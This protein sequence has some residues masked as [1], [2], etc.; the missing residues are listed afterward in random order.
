MEKV[1]FYGKVRTRDSVMKRPY[2]VIKYKYPEDGEK[3]PYREKWIAGN[4]SREFL[5]EGFLALFFALKN[6]ERMYENAEALE[7]KFKVTVDNKAVVE[8]VKTVRIATEWPYSMTDRDFYDTKSYAKCAYLDHSDVLS[9]NVYPSPE[10]TIGSNPRPLE[11]SIYSELFTNRIWTDSIA[12][13][14]YRRVLGDLMEKVGNKP[15][16]SIRATIEGYTPSEIPDRLFEKLEAYYTQV[17]KNTDRYTKGEVVLK[18]LGMKTDEAIRLI[19]EQEFTEDTF[20]DG[21]LALL[22][23]SLKRITDYTISHYDDLCSQDEENV[24]KLKSIREDIIAKSPLDDTNVMKLYKYIEEL[25]DSEKKYGT[26]PYIRQTRLGGIIGEL[27]GIPYIKDHMNYRVYDIRNPENL[28]R[29]KDDKPLEIADIRGYIDEYTDPARLDGFLKKEGLDASVDRVIG[30]GLDVWDRK[31]R[32]RN[33]YM[34]TLSL[35]LALIAASGRIL[36]IEQEDL[37][38]L[39]LPD[40]LSY[41]SRDA[42]MGM[43]EERRNVYHSY[44]SLMLPNLIRGVGDIDVI[45]I[46]QEEGL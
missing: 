31:Q 35:V 42:Y 21:E 45:D 37:S 15:Y 19:K 8:D 14:G 6:V 32:F 22:R 34:K 30:M 2:Y 3:S 23:N 39:E 33:E 20:T 10:A 16:I 24:G 18:S 27:L 11:Y 41:H 44:C 4:A 5:D 25:I 38:Y 17:I 13:L 46:D 36:G 40:F 12:G 1:K 29:Y 7:V 26:L 9:G 43:I 28:E